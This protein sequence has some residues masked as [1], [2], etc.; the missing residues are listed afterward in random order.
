M[1]RPGPAVS[2]LAWI[3]ALLLVVSAIIHIHLWSQSYQHIPTIGPLFLTQGIAGIVLA[4]T[5][6]VFRHRLILMGGALFAIGTLGGLLLSVYVGLFGFRDSL[7]APY[8]SMSLVLEA[9]AFA[10]LAG[11][12]VLTGTRARRAAQPH[13]DSQ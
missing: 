7:S 8:A 10:V 4:I 12:A 11:A 13:A 5:V 1:N 9:V 2:A 3:G 6:S